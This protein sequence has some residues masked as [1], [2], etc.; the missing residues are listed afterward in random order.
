M[1]GRVLRHSAE[2]HSA[3]RHSAE[4]YGVERHS[5]DRR[6]ARG[7]PVVALAHDYLTQRGGAERVALSMGRAFPGAPLYTTLYEP[8]QT[9]PEFGALDVRP[10]SLNRLSP[11]RRSHRLALPLL[12][13][14][15]DAIRVDAD[16]LLVSSSGWA[17]GMRSSGR[18]VVYCH[19]PARW[20]YQTQRYASGGS[21]RGAA[22]RAAVATLGYGLRRWDRE[23]ARSADRYLVNSTV[24]QRAVRDV[25]GI[26]AE[27]VPPPAACRPAGEED[28][29]PTI[30]PGFLLVVARLLPYKN[31]D[32][33]V[34]AAGLLG[35]VDVVVVGA[36]PDRDRLQSMAGPR[37]RFAGTVTDARLRWLYRH[38]SALVAASYEDYG[39]APLEAGAFGRPA[40]ALRDG[41]FLDT[42]R[43]GVSGVF[44]DTPEAEP[45]ARAIE[46]ARATAWDAATIAAHA[47]SFSEESFIDRLRTV[48]A[49]VAG[50]TP[51][52]APAAPLAAPVPTPSP[53]PAP[54]ATGDTAEIPVA[55]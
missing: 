53:V 16:V 1:G 8:S 18:K 5:A 49:D 47:D 29:D 41:G 46:R 15:V 26:E 55:A 33:V 7:E 37:V 40:I 2:R 50:R 38:A 3:E 12:A 32:A 20:L 19:A 23:A 30:E 45:I 11:L 9:F 21:M 35:D 27:V 48:V 54:V 6:V 39:L 28:P 13:H 22:T 4:R 36:G 43:E 17:H 10:S 14:D 34:R 51:L 42:V 24:I 25:Y 31:V 52:S 44:F